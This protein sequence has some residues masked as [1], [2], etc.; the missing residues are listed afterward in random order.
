MF[1]HD[2]RAHPL[3]QRIPERLAESPRPLHPIRIGRARGVGHRPPVP[4]TGTVDDP[5]RTMVQAKLALGLVGNHRHRPPTHSGGDLQTHRPQAP[6]STPHQHRVAGT[7]HVGRPAHQ[8]PIGRTRRH[9]ETA[10]LLPGEP[11]R[12]REALMG[13]SPGELAEG[14][15]V[16]LI[17]PHPRRLRKNRILA[18]QHP[19]VVGRPSGA[20]HQHFV[21]RLHPG[22]RLPHP[23]HNPRAVAPPGVEILRLATA[24]PLRNHIH[25]LAQR[26]PHVV[27]VDAAGHHIHQHLVGRHR[28]RGDHLMTEGVARLSIAFRA[29]H[30]GMHQLRHHTQR[31]PQTQ[32]TQLHGILLAR[33]PKAYPARLPRR[34]SEHVPAAIGTL[35]VGSKTRRHLPLR[36]RNG[37]PRGGPARVLFLALRARWTGP[38]GRDGV[39]LCREENVFGVGERPYPSARRLAA[40]F[41]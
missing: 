4:E 22:D 33:T 35:S 38:Q 29:H 12:L 32:I 10:R 18:R 37:N 31:R 2:R 41:P 28:R 23:P 9:Q 34:E 3:P 8:H 30:E 16:G 15:V 1:E 19:R 7:N 17:P 6:G 39:G 24:L 27:V 11:L 40:T 25:R 36:G 13:L 14:P 26:S 21:A 5:H 20:V